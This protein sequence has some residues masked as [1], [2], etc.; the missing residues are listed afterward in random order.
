MTSKTLGRSVLTTVFL[1]AVPLVIGCKASASAS[2]GGG[3]NPPPPPPPASA[4]PPAPEPKKEEP[5]KEEPK[6]EKKP[7]VGAEVKNGKVQIPGN[8][9]YETGKA[10]IKPESEPTLNQLK[11]FM[12]KNPQV[13][14]LRVEGH[15]DSDGDDAMN[16]KLSGE[17]ALA[18]VTWLTG[19]GIARDRLIAVGFGETKPLVANDTPQNKEQNR[20]TEFHTAGI[21]GKNFLGRDPTGGGTVF[22]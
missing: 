14:L 22:K 17:R 8:I 7:F 15:T 11:D 16:L 1:C 10:K 5:K 12:E 21:E 18:V 3:S 13:T 6:H 9:V 20:R 19:K 2:M 4:P